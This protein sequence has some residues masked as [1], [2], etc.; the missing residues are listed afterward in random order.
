MNVRHQ[1]IYC[2]YLSTYMYMY[3][4]IVV[5]EGAI[6]K[7]RTR[8]RHLGKLDLG[9]VL[10]RTNM[11]LSQQGVRRACFTCWARFHGGHPGLME[12]VD[13]GRTVRRNKVVRPIRL[14]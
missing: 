3:S 7:I 13:E 6:M 5:R 9:Y 11:Y 8:L 2:R 12:E 1:V 4:A 10:V 14:R